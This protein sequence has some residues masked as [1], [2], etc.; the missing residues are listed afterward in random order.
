MKRAWLLLGLCW[1]GVAGCDS[2]IVGA[3]CRS[4]Y[5]VCGS[6]CT[7]PSSDFRNCGSCGHSCGRY[8]CQEGVCSTTELRDGGT[9]DDGGA[10][11]M[12][13]GTAG[14]GGMLDGSSGAGGTSGTSG[15]SGASGSSA[16]GGTGGNPGQG[17]MSGGGD[18]NPD[19]G[20]DGCQIGQQECSGTCSNPATDPNN[21]GKCDNVCPPDQVCSGGSCSIMCDPPLI[22][23]AGQCF[24]LSEDPDH[25]GSCDNKCA[26]GI[27]E[28]GTCA[29]AVAGQAVVIGHDYV[30]PANSAMRRLAGNAIFL[31]RGA[32]VRVLTY[33]GEASA[34]SVAGVEGAIDAVKTEIGRDWMK[35]PA[36]ESIV[37]LQLAS[38][39]VLLVHS[40]FGASDSTLKKLGQ[41]WGN[42]L[43]QF[44]VTGGVVVVFETP[45]SNNT[46]T[47]K[48]LE[49]AMIFAA[50]SREAVPSQQLKV[51]TPGLGVA[52]RVPDRYMSAAETVHFN[53]VTSPGASVVVDQDGKP[54]IVQRVIVP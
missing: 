51:E 30:G 21:C 42:A 48:I 11:G 47:F 16:A 14:D 7:D 50:D 10:S 13:G 17:G 35:I 33:A 19:A 53:T 39:D 2:P 38:A 29:D 52:V 49:P 15:T 34:A 36:I 23:C 44:L 12:D 4:G 24:D 18:F 37:P 22:L 8:I 20:L 5:L 25:C 3:E 27:C 32:P 46:G 6:R 28:D 43:A 1:M 26:S 31:G 40:Q 41:A 54:V 9:P 45:S